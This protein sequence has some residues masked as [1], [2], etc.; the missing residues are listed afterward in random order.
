MH[1]QSLKLLG[2]TYGFGE[3]TITRNV[4]DGRTDVRTDVRTDRQT[5][6][7]L[8]YEI[9]IPYFS[10]EKAGIIIIQQ[11]HQTR[12]IISPCLAE[13]FYAAQH[14]HPHLYILLPVALQLLAFIFNLRVDNSVD[15]D[16]V[17]TMR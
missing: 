15:H 1:L 2:P 13:Q 9:N 11:C 6:D 8:W 16:H 5:I 10:N 4:T 7:R 17:Q 14:S 12:S 3:D